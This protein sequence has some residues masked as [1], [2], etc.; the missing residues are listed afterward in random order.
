MG[1]SLYIESPHAPKYTIN[2]VDMYNEIEW[3]AA[4]LGVVGIWGTKEGKLWGFPLGMSSVAAYVWICYG[5]KLYAHMGVNAYFF[6]VSAYGW[7]HWYEA[8]KADRGVVK[9]Y[10][11]RTRERIWALISL[12]LVFGL[13]YFFL[14]RYSDSDIALW[15]S[16][17]T[18][19]Y[20]I[21]MILMAYKRI[22]H[23]VGWIIGDVVA[24]PM[25]ISKELF[26]TAGQFMVFLLLAVAGWRRWRK[27]YREQKDKNPS[28]SIGFHPPL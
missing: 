4:L 11:C 25:Y 10:Y 19:F 14:A 23:W 28:T 6:V 1:F 8:K 24:V 18:S 16:F 27:V 26:F 13:L 17:S 3:I 9:F 22:E 20:V 15:D 7:Y 21:S 12:G 2:I 5:A